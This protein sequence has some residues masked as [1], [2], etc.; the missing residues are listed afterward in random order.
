MKVPIPMGARLIAEQCPKTHEEIYD[1]EHVPY[2]SDVGILMY[3]MVYT[4]PYIANAVGVLRRYML[5]PRNE[6]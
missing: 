2:A 1:M 5:T 4:R 3:V 6:H